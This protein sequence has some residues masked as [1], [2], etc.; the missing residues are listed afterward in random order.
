MD[1]KLP[2]SPHSRRAGGALAVALGLWAVSAAADSDSYVEKLCSRYEYVDATRKCMQRLAGQ[3]LD[4][5]IIPICER[6]VNTQDRVDCLGK[7]S[8]RGLVA[9]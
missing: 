3:F 6:W 8:E 5:Q 1:N 7:L 2:G 4:P 9:C